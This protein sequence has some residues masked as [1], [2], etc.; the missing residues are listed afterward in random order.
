MIIKEDEYEYLKFSKK[1]SI[2]FDKT[3]KAIE[4]LLNNIIA[5]WSANVEINII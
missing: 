4:G 1:S 2:F 3:T 5:V